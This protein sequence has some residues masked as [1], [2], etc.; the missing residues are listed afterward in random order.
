MPPYCAR[1]TAAALIASICLTVPSVA[2]SP[3]IDQSQLRCDRQGINPTRS[4]GGLKGIVSAS[5][6]FDIAARI[7]GTVKRITFRAGQY[8]KK[9]ELLVEFMQ[10]VAEQEVRLAE[11]AYTRASLQLL[12]AERDVRTFE[13]LAQSNATSRNR[14]FDMKTRYELAKVDVIQ[15][16][17]TLAKSKAILERFRLYAPVGGNMTAPRV[18]EGTYLEA[19]IKDGSIAR[20]MQLDTVRIAFEVPM[21]WATDWIQRSETDRHVITTGIPVRLYLPGGAV[22]KLLGIIE[23][24]AF[25]ANAETGMANVTALVP[26]PDHVLLPGMSV[27][28]EVCDKGR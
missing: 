5:R 6:S 21:A 12:V 13:Q 15:A 19:K 22:Y 7:D 14:L 28:I 3:N 8:V 16:D 10:D 24:S 9:G 27:T 23:A 20:L 11:A 25:E 4:T 18:L 1:M 26:N 2:N 17:A